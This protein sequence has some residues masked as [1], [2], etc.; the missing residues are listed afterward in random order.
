MSGMIWMALQDRQSAVDLLQQYDAGK[1]V[2][3]RHRAQR[4]RVLRGAASGLTESIR[5]PDRENYRQRIT[6]LVVSKKPRELFGRELLAPRIHQNQ[7][8]LLRAA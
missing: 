2:R 6:L 3:Y 7:G 1:F 8:R 5:R 4:E